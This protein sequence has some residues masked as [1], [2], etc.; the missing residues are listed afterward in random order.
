MW[1]NG[2]FEINGEMFWWLM[3]LSKGSTFLKIIREQPAIIREQPASTPPNLKDK[4][5]IFV[6]RLTR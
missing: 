3:A 6:V 1:A 5:Q 2:I 4:T